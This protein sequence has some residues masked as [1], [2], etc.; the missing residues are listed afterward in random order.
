LLVDAENEG[1]EDF[2][3]VIFEVVPKGGYFFLG[4]FGDGFEVVG[5]GLGV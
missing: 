4:V 3:F 5:H 1:I 2:L